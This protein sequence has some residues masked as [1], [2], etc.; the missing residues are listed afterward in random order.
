MVEV[1]TEVVK[2]DE[3]GGKHVEVSTIEV[4]IVDEMV[5]VV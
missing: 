5:V 2:G 4:L 3:I 1:G